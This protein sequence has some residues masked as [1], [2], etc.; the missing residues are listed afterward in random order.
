M[1][2]SLCNSNYN[3]LTYFPPINQGMK[4]HEGGGETSRLTSDVHRL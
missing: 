3:G 1:W 2:L 4:M